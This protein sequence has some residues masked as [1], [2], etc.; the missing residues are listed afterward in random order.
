MYCLFQLTQRTKDIICY[1]I[2]WKKGF[3]VGFN[4]SIIDVP[5]FD[6]KELSSASES[7]ICRKLPYV[8]R[9]VKKIDAV[10]IVVQS[11]CRLTEEQRCVFDNI[12]SVFGKISTSFIPL[13][14]FHDGGE[15]KAIHSMRQA[16]MPLYKGTK[17]CFNNSK[18]FS[19]N[20]H[21]EIWN[22]RQKTMSNLFQELDVFSNSSVKTTV[23]AV[24]KIIPEKHCVTEI[25]RTK[26]KV[27]NR[28]ES[29]IEFH[30]PQASKSNVQVGG[31]VK[32]YPGNICINCNMC[33]QICVFDC[34]LAVRV[35]WY[36]VMFLE[37]VCACI[38]RIFSFCGRRFRICRC[39]CK[40]RNCCF[41]RYLHRYI[42][43]TCSCSFAHHNKQYLRH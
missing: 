18:L 10:C 25:N 33:N 32:Q 39:S 4:L 21:V 11:F 30:M 43:C 13:I 36:F 27:E 14:T 35:V 41:I 6:G 29:T 17:F 7:E 8:I 22:R 20:E 26:M 38:K 5:G 9:S 15:V 23:D 31:K 2:C 1:T 28:N 19:D 12:V 34:S 42:G 24:H 40:T 37:T 16:N 3:K